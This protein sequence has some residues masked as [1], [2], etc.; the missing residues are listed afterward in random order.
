MVGWQ[1]ERESRYPSIALLLAILPCWPERTVKCLPD[2]PFDFISGQKSR[3]R[4]KEQA[5][6]SQ[7]SW[8]FLHH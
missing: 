8:V 7:L 6:A 2:S 3:L 1:Q 4:G 5:K